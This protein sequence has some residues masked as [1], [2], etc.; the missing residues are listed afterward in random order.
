V[1]NNVGKGNWLG[2]NIDRDDRF[3][4]SM[5]L[6]LRVTIFQLIEG[7]NNEGP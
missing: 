3:P 7:N 2:L 5:N 4:F 6:A 1:G